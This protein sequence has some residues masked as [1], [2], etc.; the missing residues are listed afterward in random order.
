[1]LEKLSTINK[2]IFSF[3]KTQKCFS[4]LEEK[5]PHKKQMLITCNISS[6]IINL[7]KKNANSIHDVFHTMLCIQ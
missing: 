3:F 5:N 4:E 6:F 2:E 1:M 7:N